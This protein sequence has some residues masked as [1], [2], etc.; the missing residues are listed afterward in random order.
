MVLK[1]QPTNLSI[2][3]NYTLIGRFLCSKILNRGTV[4][5][6]MQKVWNFGGKLITSYVGPNSYSIAIDSF[7]FYMRILEESPWHFMGKLLLVKEWDRS[8]SLDEIDM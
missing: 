3:V 6:M 7:D 8:L 2:H 5:T 1:L 4:Q